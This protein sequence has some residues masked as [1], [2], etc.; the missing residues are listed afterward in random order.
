MFI[1]FCFWYIN[2]KGRQLYPVPPSA[3]W[4]GLGCSLLPVP[5]PRDVPC[6]VVSHCYFVFWCSEG[7]MQGGGVGR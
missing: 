6:A 2:F 4:S 1:I 3:A 7:W 5:P